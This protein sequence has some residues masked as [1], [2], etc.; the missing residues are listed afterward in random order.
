LVEPFDDELWVEPYKIGINSHN[1]IKI[2]PAQADDPSPFK[3]LSQAVSTLL[4]SGKFPITLGGEGSITI[5]AVAACAELYP[6]LSVL[7]VDAH[8]ACR[9]SYKGNHYHHFCVG[10]QLYNGTLK[11]PLLTQVGVRNISAEEAAWME[12]TKPQINIFWARQ[13]DRWNY[14]EIVNTLSDDVY[15][16]IDLDAL[17]TS[18]MPSTSYSEPGGITWHQLTE[19]IKIL[20]IKKNVVG[21]DIVGLAPIKSFPAPDLLAAKLMY[22]LIGY[23]FALDLGVTKKYL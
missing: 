14:Q 18:I 9:V 7:Q 3:E 6:N 23:R 5:G 8:S 17:D 10:Y 1:D 20:C 2:A 12:E 22:K 11:S 13:Q 21:A 19:L 15:L 16:S 4:E